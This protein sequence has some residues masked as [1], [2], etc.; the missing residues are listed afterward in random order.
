MPDTD[1]LAKAQ[2]EEL[3]VAMKPKP[4]GKKVT[5][6]FNPETLKVSYTNPVAA[7]N[8]RRDESDKS[9]AQTP[10][11]G[12]AKLSVQLWLDVTAPV[13]SGVAAAD[14]VRKLTQELIFFV[15]PRERTAN[16]PPTSSP[17]VRFRWGS[18]QFDG[19]V[20]SLEESLEFFSSD[21]RPLRA[22]VALG[23]S[24]TQTQKVTILPTGG[25][26]PG[27]G[28]PAGTSPLSV[29]RAGSSLQQ[30]ASAAGVGKD[31]QSIASANGIE[32]PRILAPGQVINLRA[33]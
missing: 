6:Q 12:T 20:D 25:G 11:S 15:L 4:G 9:A 3:D 1:N 17:G 30:M 26:L 28:L 33:R 10:A 8:G 27:G 22:S 24:Q 16:D 14:D 13:P 18:F 31:W 32:N 23:I 21:G 2:L 7:S 5:V 29:A 19:I